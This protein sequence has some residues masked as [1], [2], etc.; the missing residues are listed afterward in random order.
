M[1]G[2]E[3][4]GKG[5][6][7]KGEGECRRKGGKEH[8]Q[9]LDDTEGAEA[10]V[11]AQDREEAVEEGHGPAELG[12]EEDDDLEEDEEPVEH[13]PEDARSLVGHGAAS[14]HYCQLH[15]SQSERQRPTHSM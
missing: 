2:K 5:G 7:K 12:E 6:D 9:A 11:V 10:E 4:L 14:A 15:R 13:R 8:A 1:K 3:D